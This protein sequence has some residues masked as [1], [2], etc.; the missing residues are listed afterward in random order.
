MWVSERELLRLFCVCIYIKES[1]VWGISFRNFLL[2]LMTSASRTRR[3]HVWL[4][5]GEAKSKTT[6]R[7]AWAISALSVRVCVQSQG[8][9]KEIESRWVKHVCVC[10]KRKEKVAHRHRHSEWNVAA[11]SE[12]VRLAMLRTH[13]HIYTHTYLSIVT[14]IRTNSRGQMFPSYYATTKTVYSAS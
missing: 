6:A 8:E 13:A 10:R 5:R 14:L 4:M 2:S 11:M 7:I 9:V 3:E 12:L 1:V